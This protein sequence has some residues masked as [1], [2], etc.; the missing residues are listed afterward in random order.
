MSFQNSLRV[1]L[2]VEEGLPLAHHT[3]VAVI[4]EGNLDGKVT[5]RAGRQF[6]VG[7]L[8]ATVTVNGP[9]FLIRI[10]GL[11]THSGGDG[12]THSSQTT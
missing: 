11:S 9:D 1:A 2:S 7:H 4:D 6:L 10:T 3:K 12:I 5:E 8:E